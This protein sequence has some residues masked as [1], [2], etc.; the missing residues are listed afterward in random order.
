MLIKRNFKILLLIAAFGVSSLA[1]A[2]TPPV[3]GFYAT[4]NTGFGP[5]F[6]IM[7]DVDLGYKINNFFATEVGA[8]A[9]STI[10]GRGDNYLFDAAAKGIMPLSNGLDLFAKLG[11]AEAHTVGQ[12]R[13]VLYTAAGIG[14]DFTT[15]VTVTLQGMLTN[16]SDDVP[17][18]RAGTIGLTY[19]F[20]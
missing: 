14:Y 3:S 19:Y 18:M 12:Y 5:D 8:A 20:N 10:G 4:V 11:L 13:A 7:G 2:E 17:S 9:F 6:R 1:I 15:N 16:K